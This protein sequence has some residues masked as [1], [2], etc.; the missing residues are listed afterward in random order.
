M[1]AGIVIMNKTAIALAADSAV[2]IGNHSAIHNSANKLFSLSKYAPVGAIIYAN[3]SFMSIPFE[4]IIKEFRKNLGKDMFDSLDGYQQKFIDFLE[5]NSSLFHFNKNEKEYV[6]E[7]CFDLLKRM[8]NDYQK[9]LEVLVNNVKRELTKTELKRIRKDAIQSIIAY[10]GE[11]E[12]LGSSHRTYVKNKY[13]DD[14]KDAIKGRFDWI[15]K[16]DCEKLKKCICEV[17]DL[18]Y[19][20]NGYVGMAIAGYGKLDIFPQVNHIVLSGVI[21][22]KLRFKTIEKRA[23]AE[24]NVASILPLAQTDVV[25]TFL[26]GINDSLISK[27][28]DEITSQIDEKIKT[29][30]NSVFASG[31]KDDLI[32]TLN[33]AT[34]TIVEKIARSA[35]E[36][37]MK[38]ILYSVSTLPIEE[39]TSFAESLVG[40]TSA[41]RQV[42]LD[43]NIGT[44]G[45]PID[46]AVI[47]KG[48]GFIWLKRKHYF[49]FKNNPH[50]LINDYGYYGGTYSDE[51]E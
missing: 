27:M 47:S 19:F 22:N 30:P 40:I 46:V 43:R 9:K 36:D 18:D 17:Y 48:D 20:R 38:P 23:I 34:P 3:A 31:K 33:D 37:Y 35:Y 51:A 25:Q 13:G 50:F 6:L 45:G 2:T 29:I 11:I 4:L 44:V 7:I 16:C 21:D 5:S 12:K 28:A 8:N 14:I 24:D 32:K 41:R 49:D 39:L 42:A 26:F 10:V 1:S 15:G